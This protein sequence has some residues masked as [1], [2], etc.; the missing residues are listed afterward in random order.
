L[1]VGRDIPLKKGVTIDYHQKS[2][3]N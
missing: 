2:T 1:L 3:V